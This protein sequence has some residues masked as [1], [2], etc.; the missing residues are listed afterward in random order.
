[1]EKGYVIGVDGGNTK[2]DLTVADLDGN[3]IATL[4]K[5]TCSH[6]AFPDSYSGACRHLYAYLDELHALAD[7]PKSSVVSAVFGLAGVDTRAQWACLDGIVFGAGYPLYQ[8]I[9]DSFL[10]IYTA[11]AD[12]LGICSINGT[13]TVAGGIDCTGKMVQVGGLGDITGDRGGGDY[14]AFRVTEAAYNEIF[15]NGPSTAL[16]SVVL[17]ALDYAEPDAL[18]AAI[19][20]KILCSTEHR[21]PLIRALFH[22]CQDDPVA[23][24]IVE[25]IAVNLANSVVGCAGH[26]S[27]PDRIPVICAGSI[28]QK[29]ETPLMF[30][31][32]RAHVEA[33]LDGRAA[34]A[35]LA[36]APVAGAV[37]WAIRNYQAAY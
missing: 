4:R 30:E 36:E 35:L 8:V 33:G 37:K 24:A 22:L 9:N 23:F 3:P 14:I 5:G 28:W 27:F 15:R 1:M 26:L 20:G 10:P 29:A 16:T 19:Q 34:V 31:R 12:G 32:F 25:E 7:I 13:K 18:C 21:L 11:G 2:T 6:E 17:D